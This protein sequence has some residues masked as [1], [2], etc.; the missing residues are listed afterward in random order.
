M[1]AYASVRLA[2]ELEEAVHFKQ[3][4]AAVFVVEGVLYHP[5]W[6]LEVE[7]V[8]EFLIE[9]LPADTSVQTRRWIETARP[10]LPLEDGRHRS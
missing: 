1:T 9:E 2:C 8:G 6:T 7:G 4:L 5:R 3:D 10:Q